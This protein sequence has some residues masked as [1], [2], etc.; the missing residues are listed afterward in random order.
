MDANAQKLCR[1][2]LALADSIPSTMPWGVTDIRQGGLVFIHDA[3]DESTTMILEAVASGL[4]SIVAAESA[5]SVHDERGPILGCL[6]RV[7]GDASDVAGKLRASYALATTTDD[8][9]PG[10]F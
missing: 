2:L 8:D 7:D 1:S 6:V 3:R 9:Q 4:G 5:P 10:P